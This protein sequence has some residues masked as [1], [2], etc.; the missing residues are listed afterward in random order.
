MKSI[1]CK[2]SRVEY[3]NFRKMNPHEARERYLTDHNRTD[4]ICG[5]GVYG[6]GNVKERDGHYFIEL[7]IGS[8]CD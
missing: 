1:E 7:E 5:Y 8:S 3:E 4:L 2:I 6:G